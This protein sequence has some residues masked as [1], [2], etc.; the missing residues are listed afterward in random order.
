MEITETRQGA[1]T[2]LKPAGPLCLG[3]ADQ[4]RSMI[5]E[6]MP[7]CL[8]RV[9]VDV[10]AVAFVDSR[11]L[12]AL[13]SATEELQAG[14]RALRLSGAGETLREAMDLTNTAERFEFFEDVNAAVRSFLA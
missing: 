3:D 10:S 4:F 7:R 13:V 5:E 12:D 9:V 11:G 14:G 6:V 8:G 2:V 1:V